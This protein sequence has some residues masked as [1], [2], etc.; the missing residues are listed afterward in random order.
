MVGRSRVDNNDSML[1]VRNWATTKFIQ[2][3][4]IYKHTGMGVIEMNITLYCAYNSL[5][6]QL[7]SYIQHV[8]TMYNFYYV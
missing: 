6:L 5:L 7:Y 4:L 2:I 1:V 8:I 3:I